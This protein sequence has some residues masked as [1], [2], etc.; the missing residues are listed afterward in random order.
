MLLGEFNGEWTEEEQDTARKFREYSKS[1]PEPL[2]Q[3]QFIEFFANECTDKKLSRASARA[4]FSRLWIKR[5]DM[6]IL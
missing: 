4:K 1:F 2:S 6:G 5:K 3:E